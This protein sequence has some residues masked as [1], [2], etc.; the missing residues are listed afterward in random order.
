VTPSR[1]HARRLLELLH[2]R[3]IA[4]AHQHHALAQALRVTGT[5][6]RAL[7]H[8]VHAGDLATTDLAERLD[9]SSAGATAL[10]QRL[11]AHG[12]VS[13]HPH[14]DDRRSTVLR[15]APATA[16]ALA[17]AEEPLCVGLD[18]LTAGL[19]GHEPATL[20]AF[21]GAVADL[22]ESLPASRRGD[23]VHTAGALERPV[24]SLWA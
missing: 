6:V 4:L 10:V 8:L 9:L 21:L 1:L 14:P 17:D 24:P 20:A 3:D 22:Y 19:R 5:E 2:R 18:A 15:V 13:R 7:I 11:V 16:A 23:R 12:H